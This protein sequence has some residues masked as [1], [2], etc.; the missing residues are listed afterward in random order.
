MIDL[1]DHIRQHVRYLGRGII[2]AD[3]FINHQ[4]VPD[5][6]QAMGQAFAAAFEQSGISR[7]TRILTAEVS[8]I[9]PALVT[10]QTLGIPMVFARKKRPAFMTG[11][12][13]CAE[14]KSRTKAETVRLHV[15]A[16]FLTPDDRVL[17][18]DD[19][20]A[21]ASTLNALADIVRQSR[22]TLIGIGCIVEK[23]FENGRQALLHLGVPIISLARVDLD[24]SGTMIAVS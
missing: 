23:S 15:S 16:D 13:Y 17:I 11:E 9:A 8:G 18:V 4:L 5:L 21:T 7:P 3:S 14:A 1:K 24:D 2:K 20:L 12:L 10:A 19:F 22:A 6:A